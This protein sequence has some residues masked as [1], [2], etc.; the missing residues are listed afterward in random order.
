MTTTTP[1]PASSSDPN[2][3]DAIR[4]EIDATREQLSD[5][6]DLLAARLDVKSRASQKVQD[7]R[8]QATQ[9]VQEVRS[10]ATQ[11]AQV[12]RQQASGGVQGARTWVQ[13]TWDEH[14][15]PVIAASAAV[16]AAVV[17]ALAARRRR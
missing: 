11:R 2:D 9:R 4:R 14:Q 1:Q 13:Q 7:V 8:T 6:V 12:A 10:Q 3:P 5:T 16:V 17:V 15:Q